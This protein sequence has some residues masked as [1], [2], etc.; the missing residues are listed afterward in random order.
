M[1]RWG[2][3]LRRALALR[4]RRWSERVLSETAADRP[5]SPPWP[6]HALDDGPPEFWLQMVRERAPQW[7]ASRPELAAAWRGE[8]PA[9]HGKERPPARPDGAQAVAPLGSSH[10]PAAALSGA[11]QAPGDST[12]ADASGAFAE[13]ERMLDAESRAPR[14]AP[15]ATDQPAPGSSEA[16]EPTHRARG[17]LHALPRPPGTSRLGLFSQ[18]AMYARGISEGARRYFQ[19]AAQSSSGTRPASH[20]QAD[21]VPRSSGS[22]LVPIGRARGK[23]APRVRSLQPA[24]RSPLGSSAAPN[25]HAPTRGAASSPGARS[26]ERQSGSP[27][28]RPP[29]ARQPGRGRE[30]AWPI[31]LPQRAGQDNASRRGAPEADRARTSTSQDFAN[32]DEHTTASWRGGP[33]HATAGAG[34]TTHDAKPQEPRKRARTVPPPLPARKRR[35]DPQGAPVTQAPLHPGPSW[36]AH[37]AGVRWTQPGQNKPVDRP[38]AQVGSGAVVR[39]AARLAKRDPSQLPEWPSLPPSASTASTGATTSDATQRQAPAPPLEAPTPAADQPLTQPDPA[40]WPSLPAE[41]SNPEPTRAK[42]DGWESFEA[43]DEQLNTVRGL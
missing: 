5:A 41:P 35:D 25:Q 43:I 2:V 18:L 37:R 7:L 36:A 22:G 15:L 26:S 11:I 24:Q 40:A 19:F 12:H 21:A 16:C 42:P 31:A 17:P 4:L 34:S 33:Q 29:A 32:G 39:A 3:R 6:P 38:H 1:N 14:R 8:P 27:G 10:G 30:S 9:G 20:T 13:L 23:P 28:A